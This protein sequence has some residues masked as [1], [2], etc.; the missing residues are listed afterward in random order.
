MFQLIGKLEAKTQTGGQKKC[1]GLKINGKWF[2]VIDE[3]IQNILNQINV[4]ELIS[5]IVGENEKTIIKLERLEIENNDIPNENKENTESEKI[6]DKLKTKQEEYK[7]EHK[8]YKSS[9]DYINIRKEELEFKYFQQ[10]EILKQVCL[11]EA[12]NLTKTLIEKYNLKETKNNKLDLD[13]TLDKIS[14]IVIKFYR[15][16][17]KEVKNERTKED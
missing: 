12:V 11:K 10:E 3:E 8:Q 4:G 5:V 16:F 14:Q 15:E 6:K 1:P 13:K 9:E 2:D 17:L 7:Q